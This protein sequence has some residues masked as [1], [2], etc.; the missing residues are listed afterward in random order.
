MWRLIIILI[1][2]AFS[3]GCQKNKG[4]N[5]PNPN[6]APRFVQKDSI[7][8]SDIELEINPFEISPLAALAKI[9]TEKAT[10]IE[11]H[12]VGDSNTFQIITNPSTYHEAPIFGLFPNQNNLIALKIIESESGNWTYDTMAIQTEPLPD[13]FPEIE[14]ETIRP[15]QM[16]PG[17]NLIEMSFGGNGRFRCYPM[18][19]DNEGVVRWYLNLDFFEGFIAPFEPLSNGNWVFGRNNQVY[20]YDILGKKVSQWYLGDYYQHHDVFEKANGNFIVPVTKGGTDSGLD[21]IIELDRENGNVVR[22]WDLR[23][24]LDVDRFDLHWHSWDWIHVNSVWFD[25]SDES[26]LIS[27][28]SQGIVKVTEN[29]ELQWILAPHQGW[30]QA[31]IDGMG[32][33]TS[34]YL[35]DAYTN[36]TRLTD[37]IQQGTEEGLDFGWAWGQHACLALPTGNI[38]CYDNSWKRTFVND[39]PTFSRAVEYEI[40]AENQ[41]VRQVWEYGRERGLET[42]AHNISD[43]DYL[44]Q[45]GNRLFCPG[46]IDEGA[47][48]EA[49]MV[50][51]TYPE[52]ELVFEAVIKF[53]NAFSTSSSWGH[54]DLI[55]RMERVNLFEN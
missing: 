10:T 51:V 13:F 29:N 23:Q 45:T 11:Y 44:P 40:D 26:L 8:S 33:E 38:F 30:G 21:F 43:V 27:G 54:A 25:E 3:W 19:F 15:N 16:E 7:Y 20:E 4:M 9:N 49:R 32:Y 18:I 52:K 14:I 48:K 24:V 39:P 55:Y 46:N 35:L 28:R 17:W 53:K 12:L 31:G 34:N 41:E 36:Q 5:L 42:T 22:E 47:V 50:E 2:F 1:L 6:E 37:A